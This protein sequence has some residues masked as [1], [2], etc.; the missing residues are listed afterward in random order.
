[1]LIYQLMFEWF[2]I[3]ISLVN[4]LLLKLYIGTSFI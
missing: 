2:L 3:F 1:M 4:N